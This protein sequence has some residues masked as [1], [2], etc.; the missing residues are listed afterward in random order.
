MGAHAAS[1]G[2]LLQASGEVDRSGRPKG[3]FQPVLG[4][5]HSLKRY[6]TLISTQMSASRAKDALTYLQAS[7]SGTQPWSP[8]VRAVHLC[9]YAPIICQLCV[10]EFWQVTVH[11][12]AV[13]AAPKHSV[14]AICPQH[15]A[16][17]G[18]AYLLPT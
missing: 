8:S 2:L 6:P 7:L 17:E 1:A 10:A 11:R 16:A 18:E 4:G 15:N 3:F 12:L 14:C 9:A 5:L 13:T